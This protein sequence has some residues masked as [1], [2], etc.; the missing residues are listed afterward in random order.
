LEAVALSRRDS[1]KTLR[2]ELASPYGDRVYLYKPRKRDEIPP[3]S[4]DVVWAALTA[5]HAFIHP[6][7]WKLY[8]SHGGKTYESAEAILDDGWVVE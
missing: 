8:G 4:R 6:G 2:G 1:L 3:D 5:E 7:K